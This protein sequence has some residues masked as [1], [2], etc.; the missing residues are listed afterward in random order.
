MLFN[1]FLESVVKVKHLELFGEASHAKL[2]PPYRLELAK[3]M[4]ERAKSARKAGV[5]ALF[6]P[7]SEGETYLVLILRKTYK[8]VHSAQVG[9][10]GGKYENEDKDLM[11]TALRETEEE[12]G[13]P[14]SML[15][16]IKSM[17]PIYIPPSNFM[18]H[19]YLA[20]SK[21][22]PNFIKQDEEVEAIIEVK[23]TDVLDESNIITTRVPTSFNVEV[24]VP[25]FKLNHEIVWGA[26]AMMLSELK[27]LLK[28][29]L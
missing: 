29:V 27:D 8:G 16:V 26:T 6:Y 4:K 21:T 5:M 25:A 19:P 2:S 14:V 12:V 15:E 10:P 3:K 22:T 7:N 17:T 28:Q 11:V 1:T 9:F 18:V 13:V 23:L 20:V 24:D